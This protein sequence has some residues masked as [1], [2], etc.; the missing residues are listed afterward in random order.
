[1][2]RLS[3]RLYSKMMCGIIIA[4][5]GM[6]ASMAQAAAA[7]TGSPYFGRWTIENKEDQFSAKGRSYKTIDIAPCGKDFCGVSVNTASG[8]CGPTLFRFLSKNK[9]GNTALRGH[10]KWGTARKN[11]TVYTYDD[12][13]NDKILSLLL[14]NGVALNERSGSMIIFDG[15]YERLGAA[16]CMTK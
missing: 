12:S 16:K 2:T 3:N 1:M 7:G 4:S 15:S 8:T 14:S 9:A 13:N 6:T 5:L 10:G 11:I